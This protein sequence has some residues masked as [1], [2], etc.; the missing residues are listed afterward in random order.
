MMLIIKTTMMMM[1]MKMDVAKEWIV[2]YKTKWKLDAAASWQIHP[3]KG[4][5]T[6]INTQKHHDKY[7]QIQKLIQI[8]KYIMKNTSKITKASWQIHGIAYVLLLNFEFYNP[9]FLFCI[10]H[11]L[12]S[13]LHFVSS[14]ISCLSFVI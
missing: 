10:F 12:L 8:H 9:H 14:C 7:I 6:Y 13:I 3:N 1:M 11:G 4:L 2:E 5:N